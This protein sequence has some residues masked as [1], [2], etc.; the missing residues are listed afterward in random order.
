MVGLHHT[1]L[2]MGLLHV[3]HV[4][5]V[6]A[7]LHLL[8][9][10]IDGLLGRGE[11]CLGRLGVGARG[12][13][14]RGGGQGRIHLLLLGLVGQVEGLGC[15][16]RCCRLL[17]LLVL[18]RTGSWVVRRTSMLLWTTLLALACRCG[19][20]LGVL[21]VRVQGG[22]GV[23]VLLRHWPLRHIHGVCL[24]WVLCS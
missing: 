6:V 10:D 19:R 22:V 20:G 13:G 14:G 12:H 18:D 16:R 15:G 1:R 17:V 11:R 21:R 5:V 23:G 3:R 24:L 8:R 7:V 9:V 2:H 4:I